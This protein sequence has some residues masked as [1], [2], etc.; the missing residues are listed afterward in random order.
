MTGTLPPTG[1]RGIGGLLLG[2][3][4]LTACKL[5]PDYRPPEREVPDHWSAGGQ[6]AFEAANRSRARSDATPEDAWWRVFGDATL[7]HLIES[8]THQNLDV[9]QA[10]LRIAESRA[11]RDIAAAPLFPKVNGTG[12]AA[13][14]RLSENG[15]GTALSGSSSNGGSSMSSMPSW[16]NFFQAGFD[17]TWELDLFGRVRRSVEAADAEVRSAEAARAAALVSLRA[18]IARVYFNLLGYQRQ[19]NIALDEVEA[20]ERRQ[21]LVTSRNHSGLAPDSEVA[22]QRTQLSADRATIPAFEQAIA[23]S[24][25]RLALL[26]A[27]PPGAV[28]ATGSQLPPLPPEVPVGL[29]GDLLRRRPD[30][31]ERESEL[32]A[33][34]ARI[35][36]AEATLFPRVTLGAGAG[37]QSTMSSTLFDW[38][39]RFFAGGGEVSLPIFAGGQLTGQVRIAN[40]QQ[41]GAL[42]AYRQVVLNAFHEVDDALIAYAADQRRASAVQQQ[43]DGAR[44]SRE[45]AEARYRDG[46][47]PYIEVLDADRQAH[48][49][50]QDLAQ[51]EVAAAADLIALFKALGGGFTGLQS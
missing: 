9:A 39:S 33:A 41:Q 30:I 10:E 26:L 14:A 19:L 3:L 24:E 34:T 17:A 40:L 42:L 50:E 25:N 8:A 22:A 11:Q 7:D 29:P 45:L 20:Q 15:L 38:G 49:A 12:I 16:L 1:F 44:R 31:R 21:T 18:E 43:L 27:L 6:S 13:R 46:L 28:A 51:A 4:L 32:A 47:S 35:G 23:Q 2:A 5:G 36:V 37:F 48:Q